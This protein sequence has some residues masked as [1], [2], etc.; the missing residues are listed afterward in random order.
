MSEKSNSLQLRSELLWWKEASYSPSTD[1]SYREIVDGII[2][3]IIAKDYS[4]FVPIIYPKSA[5]YFLK[6]T[7]LNLKNKNQ[8]EIEL[9]SLITA[10]ENNST[11][12]RQ[13]FPE[14]NAEAGKITLLS[15]LLGIIWGKYQ[16][17]QFEEVLGFAATVKL[18][19]AELTLWLFHDF[20][21]LKA[22]NIK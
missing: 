17:S 12:L 3:I 8:E 10:L 4:S 9:K 5:D 13:L 15:Y 22:V 18:F 6:E 7:Y 1:K 21:L 14:T 16:V 2:E 11:E 20:Q 19:P